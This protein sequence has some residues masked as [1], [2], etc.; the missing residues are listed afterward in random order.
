ML[1]TYQI[2]IFT[3]SAGFE[4]LT[5]VAMKRSIFRDIKPC[6]PLKANRRICHLHLQGQKISQAR[7]QRKTGSNLCWFLLGLS[8]DPE[9]G[10]MFFPKRRLT[11]NGL[12]GVIS[13][14]TEFFFCFP[15]ESIQIKIQKYSFIANIMF[16]NI[17]HYPVLSKNTALFIY[18][19]T[20]FR[21]LDF[22]SVFR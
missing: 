22:V 14:K 16:L 7:N 4:V 6:R 20:T 8:F 19:N 11:F 15:P 18:Q 10:D 12:H 1:S 21:R 3:L 2:R 5:A 9:D 17:I 13:Q